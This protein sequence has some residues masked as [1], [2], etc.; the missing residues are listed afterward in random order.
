MERGVIPEKLEID[1]SAVEDSNAYPITVTLR[2]LSEEEATPAQF[3]HKEANGLFRSSLTTESEIAEA[4]RQA[5]ES[6]SKVGLDYISRLA[7][8]ELI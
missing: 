3:G 6:R 8:L 5:F 1:E 4:E 7:W 2:Y